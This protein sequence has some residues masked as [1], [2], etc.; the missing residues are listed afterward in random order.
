MR[1]N[2]LQEFDKHWNCLEL[3]NQV[4]L[5]PLPQTRTSSTSPCSGIPVLPETGAFTQQVHVRKAGT[6]LQEVYFFVVLTLW[7][8]ARLG[9]R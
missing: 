1:E 8:F 3:N 4:R 2:C 7:H 5:L 9:P 6:S